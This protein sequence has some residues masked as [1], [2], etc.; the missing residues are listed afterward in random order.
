MDA[1]KQDVE[2]A[3]SPYT[4]ADQ[5]PRMFALQRRS[6]E[7]NINITQQLNNTP[8]T[9]NNTIKQTTTSNN[10]IIKQQLH[11]PTEPITG[12]YRGSS[13]SPNATTNL[14]T[15][16]PFTGTYR[17]SVASSSDVYQGHSISGSTSG[18]GTTH[19]TEI[20]QPNAS[21]VFCKKKK[22][23]SNLRH[24]VLFFVFKSSDLFW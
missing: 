17:G 18:G 1:N 6:F 3:D 2:A 5:L 19:Y 4:P 10:N 23:I 21:Y 7:N 15:H 20:V 12:T 9:S 11:Q 22:I 24:F 16:E 8:T 13:I 14:A